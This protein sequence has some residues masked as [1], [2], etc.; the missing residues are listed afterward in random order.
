MVRELGAAC[1]IQP[2]AARIIWGPDAVTRLGRVAG[3]CDGLA[4]QPR[5]HLHPLVFPKARRRVL[6]QMLTRCIPARCRCG[7]AAPAR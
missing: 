2:L 3:A 6:R 4:N 7:A 5:H 1:V